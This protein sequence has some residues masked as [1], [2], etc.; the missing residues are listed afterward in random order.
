[1]SD[2]D[3]LAATLYVRQSRRE[4]EASRHMGA[5]IRTYAELRE[6]GV[7]TLHYATFDTGKVHGPDVADC[8]CGWGRLCTG[9][10]HAGRCLAYWQQ[11]ARECGFLRLRFAFACGVDGRSFGF[12]S[13]RMHGPDQPRALV[14]SSVPCVDCRERHRHAFDC[15]LNYARES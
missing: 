3:R 9:P 1:M 14:L 10:Y 7:D 12:D 11:R 6:I 2:I 5:P 8:G 15:P 13:G 4:S